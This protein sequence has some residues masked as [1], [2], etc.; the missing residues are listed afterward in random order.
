M[1]I[2]GLGLYRA[3]SGETTHNATSNAPMLSINERVGFKRHKEVINVQI[4]RDKL[5][6]FLKK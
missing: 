6:E 4:M 1:P 3:L 2:F 5:A